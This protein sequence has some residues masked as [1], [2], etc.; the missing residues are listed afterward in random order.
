MK[1]IFEL[2]SF[3]KNRIHHQ[4]KFQ[5]PKVGEIWWC[6]IGMNIGTEIYGKGNDFTRPV[7]VINAEGSES[8][9]GI[10]L[11]SKIR[12]TKYSYTIKTNDNKLHTV[13]FYQ[14]R[15]FDKRRLV[16]RVYTLSD[17][18]MNHVRQIFYKIFVI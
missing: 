2:W 9:I 8:F 1:N 13:L 4:E 17:S 5:H 18:E 7:L 16:R 10:P 6:S 14:I 12:N 11:S 15:N 3:I